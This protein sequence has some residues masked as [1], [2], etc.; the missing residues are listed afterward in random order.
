MNASVSNRSY[1]F[2]TGPL[3]T[4]I[5]YKVIKNIDLR[6]YQGLVLSLFNDCNLSCNPIKLFQFFDTVSEVIT[7]PY[8]IQET[9]Y[10]IENKTKKY[11]FQINEEILKLVKK[12]K[13]IET[14]NIFSSY[15]TNPQ[16]FKNLDDYILI[17][18]GLA[19]LSLVNIGI[20]YKPLQVLT[21]DNR[22]GNEL[23]KKSV[24]YINF[25]G[26]KWE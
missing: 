3:F 14:D 26:K 11:S 12:I 4:F 9:M 7:T 13:I 6:K 5:M 10:H 25:L 21:T 1:L 24:G 23:Y 2:D 22:L 17:D 19:D 8:I 20:Q 18:Y 16:L 15:I